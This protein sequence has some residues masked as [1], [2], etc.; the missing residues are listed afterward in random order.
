MKAITH[1]ALYSLCT[2]AMVSTSFAKAPKG[3][4]TDVEAAIAL[5]KKENKAVL[6]AFIG[7]DWCPPCIVLAKK[8]FTKKEFVDKASKDFV[9]VHIDFPNGD[10]ELAEKNLPY[11]EKYQIPG[12]PAVVLL[13][14]E[15]NEFSR[16]FAAQYLDVQPFLGR[17]ETAVENKDID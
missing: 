17:L 14:S 8:V 3:W 9:L 4:H 5:A 15:G 11:A 6:L 2:A 16:F 13:D 7:S 12:F 1:L 10:A